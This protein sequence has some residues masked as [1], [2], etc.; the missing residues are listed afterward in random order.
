[1][2]FIEKTDYK[3]SVRPYDLQNKNRLSTSVKFFC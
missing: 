3:L 1:M 2:R